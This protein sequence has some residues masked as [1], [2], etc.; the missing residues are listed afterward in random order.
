MLIQKINEV[1]VSTCLALAELWDDPAQNNFDCPWDW[2]EQQQT[3]EGVKMAILGS[4]P[5]DR[6]AKLLDQFDREK[7]GYHISI[8]KSAGI[9]KAMN[10]PVSQACELMQ[11]AS[12]N[13]SRRKIQPR[14]IENAIEWAYNHVCDT[15]HFVK[16]TPEIDYRLIKRACDVGDIEEMRKASL[17]IPRTPQDALMG[18]FKGDDI[19]YIASEVFNGEAMTIDKWK[20]MALVE[21]QYIC[22]NPLK[23]ED[24]GRVM[25]NIC[26]NRYAV[27]ES[28]IPE[29]AGNWDG[30]AGVIDRLSRIVPL[31]MIV[32]SGNKSLHAWFDL[33]GS[34]E[35]TKHRFKNMAIKMGADPASLRPTQLVR[36]PW[37]TRDNKKTQK[38]IYYH[39]RH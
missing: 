10:I 16:A 11:K 39:G 25:T 24:D 4:D 18:L 2:R 38:V 13:V 37:G 26:D 23:S 30:Q 15:K 31:R 12:D 22:P 33:V 9:M 6:F 35:S 36:L 14:E 27:F 20:Y 7:F 8:L 5:G 19:L 29:L 1:E 28:D 34:A 17:D 21:S 3:K 32:W